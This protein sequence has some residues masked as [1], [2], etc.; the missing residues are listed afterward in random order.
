M[1]HKVHA[2]MLQNYR[3]HQS[4]TTTCKQLLVDQNTV[5]DGH[6]LQMTKC[7]LQYPSVSDLGPTH[8]LFSPHS[9][10]VVC[11]DPVYPGR[12]AGQ[13]V[14]GQVGGEVGSEPRLRVAVTRGG[15]CT[16]RR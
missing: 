14:G 6:K 9:A 10:A 11:A 16:Q 4:S 1:D 3:A 13:L 15:G 5:M 8:R 7:L 2:Q 12:Q